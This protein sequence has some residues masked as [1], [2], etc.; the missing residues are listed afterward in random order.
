MKLY[1]KS[2][3]LLFVCCTMPGFATVAVTSPT[4]GSTIPSPV[5]YVASATTTTCSKGVAAMGIYINN[6]LIYVVNSTILNTN[7]TM[8]S[9]A[10]H[11]VVEEW[12]YCGGATFTTID[13]TVGNP[14]A[15]TVSIT[16]DPPTI[17]AGSTSTLSVT[18][19]NSTQVTVAGSNGTTYHLSQTGGMQI[20]SP[21]AT[22]TYTAEVSGTGGTASALSTVDV[23]PANAVN[24]VTHV[25]FM[26]QENR[27]FDNYFGMLNPYRKSNGWNIGDDGK[28]Y[29]VDGVD[30]KLNTI[31][32][33]DDQGNVY[34]LF[35][36][37]STCVDD[38]SSAW[39]ES[40]GDV[41]RWDF[42]TTRNI[43]MDGFVHIGEGYAKS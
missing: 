8:N 29:E 10:E 35:K 14:P 37:K 30:D 4:A 5:H 2:V 11:T 19:T 22:T 31:S 6:V 16:A 26:L 36:L 43:G 7:I 23:M 1:L 42:S 9:G 15:P 21:A 12:D 18:A 13:I 34:P 40:Y 27:T 39:L 3:F 33:Q 41:N 28:D 25:V 20:V 24:S 17:Q 38:D 32:N